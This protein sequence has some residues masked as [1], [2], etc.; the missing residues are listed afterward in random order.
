MKLTWVILTGLV[1]VAHADNVTVPTSEAD[2]ESIN[3]YCS[4]PDQPCLKMKRAAE[5]VADALAEPAPLPEAEADAHHSHRW[6]F[7][8][9]E[10]CFKAKR[11]AIA[12]AEAFAD[13]HAAANPSAEAG[14][15]SLVFLFP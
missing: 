2:I 11:S 7:F 5:A 3:Q 12:V 4:Q 14:M 13:A 15:F 6:C 9:G 1:A 10:P 8:T